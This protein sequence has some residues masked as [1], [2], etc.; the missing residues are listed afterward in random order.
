MTQPPCSQRLVLY[1]TWERIGPQ[2]NP[3][4]LQRFPHPRY[5]GR[6]RN[7]LRLD[8]RQK[9]PKVRYRQV[10]QGAKARPGATIV[11]APQMTQ[12]AE[13]Q[14]THRQE[15][16]RR[17][18]ESN[19]KAEIIGGVFLIYTD[20]SPAGFGTMLAG[21]GPAVGA[22]IYR[23]RSARAE[24]AGTQGSRETSV[25][26]STPCSYS[27]RGRPRPSWPQRPEGSSGRIRRQPTQ[28]PFDPTAS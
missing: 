17:V 21:I 10:R 4:R 19:S 2:G 15:I 1:G 20:K 11:P 8:G 7:A 3:K 28:T 16:E 27:R 23:T 12:M 25:A 24:R 5:C 18:I 9:R 6:P 13:N 26:Y 14:A 22:F